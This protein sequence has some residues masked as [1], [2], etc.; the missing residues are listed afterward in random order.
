MSR[1]CFPL[2]QIGERLRRLPDR[3]AARIAIETEQS[4][5]GKD[6]ASHSPALLYRCVSLQCCRARD[7][8]FVYLSSL[9]DEDGG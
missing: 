3:L 6:F 2:V 5:E 8:I 1:W 9:P 4:I 7:A